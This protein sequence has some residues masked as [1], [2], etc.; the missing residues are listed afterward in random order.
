MTKSSHKQVGVVVDFILQDDQCPCMR[1]TGS[2]A[3]VSYD[4][5]IQATS[6]QEA[7]YTFPNFGTYSSSQ[8]LMTMMNN[9]N[10]NNNR[11]FRPTSTTTTTYACDSMDCYSCMYA[12]VDGFAT[13][14]ADASN[15][16]EWR[17]F[18]SWRYKLQQQWMMN[19]SG[20][21]SMPPCPAIQQQNPSDRMVSNLSSSR[22]SPAMIDEIVQLMQPDSNT[23]SNSNN[24]YRQRYRR[25][26]KTIGNSTNNG[27]CMFLFD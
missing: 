15:A 25:K 11:L 20:D 24:Y 22:L 21:E 19:R 6:L 7:I 8:T 3:C 13:S 18:A 16:I 14:A 2:S 12:I 9:N 5:S 27:Q 10:N 26:M 17:T 1:P 23:P 4:Q